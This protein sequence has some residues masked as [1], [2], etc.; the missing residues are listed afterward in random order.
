MVGILRRFG[1]LAEFQLPVLCIK[2]ETAL[3]IRIYLLESILIFK[4]ANNSPSGRLV[5]VASCRSSYKFIRFA[6]SQEF[7]S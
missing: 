5:G 1:S 7:V 2:Y 6:A 3:I 4:V